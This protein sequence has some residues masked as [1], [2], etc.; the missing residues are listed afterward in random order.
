MIYFLWG[1]AIRLLLRILVIIVLFAAG[2]G[3]ALLQVPYVQRTLFEW[4]MQQWEAHKGIH[5][6]VE[7]FYG[8]PPFYI[9]AKEV[10]YVEDGTPWIYSPQVSVSFSPLELLLK[11]I[12][13]T[14]M[15]VEDPVILRRVAK[16]TE[17][18][19]SNWSLHFNN[20]EVRNLHVGRD[21]L[22]ILPD[23]TF[24]RKVKSL[25]VLNVEGTAS[26][27]FAV[28]EWSVDALVFEGENETYLHLYGKKNLSP[29]ELAIDFK[30]EEDKRGGLFA[31]LAFPHPTLD[32]KGDASL[33]GNFQ[34]WRKLFNEQIA[35]APPL[36][37]SVSLEGTGSENPLISPLKITSKVALSGERSLVF[38]GLKLELPFFSSEGTLALSPTLQIKQGQFN[39]ELNLLPLGKKEGWDLEGSLKGTLF[40]E[41]SFPEPKLSLEFNEQAFSLHKEQV[42]LHAMKLAL[43]GPLE[44]VQGEI[45][46]RAEYQGEQAHLESKLQWQDTDLHLAHLQVESSVGELAGDLTILTSERLLKGRLEG[47]WKEIYK[48]ASA[49]GYPYSGSLQMALSFQPEKEPNSDAFLQGSKGSLILHNTQISPLKADLLSFDFDLVA[50]PSFPYFRGKLDAGTKRLRWRCFEIEEAF[51]STGLDPQQEQ[52]PYHFQLSGKRDRTFAIQGSGLWKTPTLSTNE[53]VGH[54][55]KFS[56]EMENSQFLLAQPT[57]FQ[58]GINSFS[59]TSFELLLSDS[60]Q[61]TQQGN[62]FFTISKTEKALNSNWEA[63][64]IPLA[65]VHELCPGFHLTG[66]LSG[67]GKLETSRGNVIGKSEFLFTE[68]NS[69]EIPLSSPVDL[70]LSINLTPSELSLFGESLSANQPFGS[71]F[72]TTPLTF[73][74][75]TLTPTFKEPAPLKGKVSF[76]GRVGPAATFFLEDRHR[77]SGNVDLAMDIAG[78]LDE[79]QLIGRANFTNGQYESLQTGFTLKDIS[80][81]LEGKGNELILKNLSAN[82]GP[83]KTLQGE[84]LLHLNIPNHFPYWLKLRP[85]NLTLFQNDFA[86]VSIKGAVSLEGD[87]QSAVLKGDITFSEVDISIPKKLPTILPELEVTYLDENG[88][89]YIPLVKVEEKQTPSRYPITL[90][91]SAKS[92]GSLFLKGRGLDSEWRGSLQATGS[93]YEPIIHGVFKIKRGT[94]ELAGKQ[95]RITQGTLT[96]NGTPQQAS[97]SVQAEKQLDNVKVYASLKGPVKNPQLNLYSSPDLPRAEIVSLFL[98]NKHTANISAAEGLQLVQTLNTLS[99]AEGSTNIIGNIQ[100]VVG[101]DRLN[102]DSTLVEETGERHYLVHAGKYIFKGV[103]LSFNKCIN[104]AHQSLGLEFG[105]IR[106]VKLEAELSA[107][108]QSM[109]SLKWQYDY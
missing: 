25:P 24:S 75:S 68:L 5:L 36:T 61:K 12:V 54:L 45:S 32:L 43:S 13:F 15:T 94:F 34:T 29:A 60:H 6:E 14:R 57:A 27:Y 82:M 17:P 52:N 49:F 105:L 63:N 55:D 20:V 66:F 81:L 72:L 47:R 50:L 3:L 35:H 85:D 39:T 9:T 70:S 1:M 26:I 80:F 18:T 90:D 102:V 30:F 95:M 19:P 65:L 73:D 101:I 83:S 28:N 107:D 97:V 42:I 16:E 88:R 103:L 46:L 78:T 7:E 31:S 69:T 74:A 109:I 22:D 38:A 99:G 89:P 96:L 10:T 33:S 106:N 71:L 87:L 76:S 2:A 79:P 37:G 41:G 11:R 44:K 104:S 59:L 77:V 108:G 92:R 58:L 62:L 53:L 64:D 100:R 4:G 67:H 48:I 56:V 51:F 21:L 93:V 23:N 84:G 86:N 98:F 40:L 8:F 91:I